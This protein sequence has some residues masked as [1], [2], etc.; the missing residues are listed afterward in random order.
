M[1]CS[2]SSDRIRF[3]FRRV[4]GPPVAMNG[5]GR[6]PIDVQRTPQIKVQSSGEVRPGAADGHVDFGHLN[7][8]PSAGELEPSA[9]H[10]RE[11]VGWPTRATWG[12]EAVAVTHLSADEPEPQK[13]HRPIRRVSQGGG[14]PGAPPGGTRESPPAATHRTAPHHP[15]HSPF[16][17]RENV[18]L[19]AGGAALSRNA[20]AI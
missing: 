13:R 9:V 4:V 2:S 20:N 6:A 15:V 16:D 5:R 11:L 7:I 19:C 14:R 17:E 3:P 1:G 12:P 8:S 18:A 10:R